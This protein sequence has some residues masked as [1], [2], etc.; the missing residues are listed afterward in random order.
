M[1]YLYPKSKNYSKHY[2]YYKLKL[3]I[4]LEDVCIKTL[5][6]LVC[7]ANLKYSNGNRIWVKLFCLCIHQRCVRKT[8]QNT[9]K[10]DMNYLVINWICTDV[11]SN[12]LQLLTLCIMILWL[13]YV[14][15]QTQQCHDQTEQ[16]KVKQFYTLTQT[17]WH[18]HPQRTGVKNRRSSLWKITLYGGPACML[19][20][21]HV[22][23]FLACPPPL[24]PL[25]KISS[26]A[27]EC[28]R[29]CALDLYWIT[30]NL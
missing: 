11:E 22:E 29:C 30:N 15:F 9:K 10:I 28:W 17:C 8:I 20:F 5:N 25:T 27:H 18:A 13:A 16:W 21:L 19:L 6:V 26:G 2:L 12:I 7:N 1:G 4:I 23:G 14:H 3:D 24:P